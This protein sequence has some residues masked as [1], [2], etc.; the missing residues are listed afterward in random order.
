MGNIDE[1]A[2]LDKIRK[3][4]E[5]AGLFSYYYVSSVHYTCEYQ[6]PTVLMINFLLGVYSKV[7]M[8]VR[9]IFQKVPDLMQELEDQVEEEGGGQNARK[10]TLI[11]LV[12]EKVCHS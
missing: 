11:E 4:L 3:L 12:L 8:V 9:R 1:E 10:K 5:S 2:M 7:L 6:I